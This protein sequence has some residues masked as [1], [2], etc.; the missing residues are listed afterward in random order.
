MDPRGTTGHAGEAD[1]E[2]PR[3]FLPAAVRGVRGW[4]IELEA[5][6][7]EELANHIREAWRLVA[8]KTLKR[9]RLKTAKATGGRHIRR[10]PGPGEGGRNPPRRWIAARTDG[11]QPLSIQSFGGGQTDA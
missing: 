2:E 1:H 8:P 4:V 11:Y 7:E 10:N 3:T 6:S 9:G 5:I